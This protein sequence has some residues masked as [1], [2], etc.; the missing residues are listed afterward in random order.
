MA[1]FKSSVHSGSTTI[2][3]FRRLA[4]V[5][6]CLA[7]IMIKVLT[8]KFL[9]RDTKLGLGNN[10]WILSITCWKFDHWQQNLMALTVDLDFNCGC[11]LSICV[12]FIPEIMKM[13]VYIILRSAICHPVIAWQLS[14]SV[15]VCAWGITE[16]LVV[17][18]WYNVAITI[19]CEFDSYSVNIFW[20][21]KL[22]QILNSL[23]IGIVKFITGLFSKCVYIA[24]DMVCLGLLFTVLAVTPHTVLP[25]TN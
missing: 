23:L 25:C 17:G 15:A 10:F 14:P 16:W 20:Q 11:K 5:N 7:A 3:V 18:I 19:V 13:K 6:K 24:R 12:T 2:E 21:V 22:C 8:N 9:T 1:S 4:I